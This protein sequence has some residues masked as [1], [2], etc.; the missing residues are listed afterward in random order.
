[1]IPE[2]HQMEH[3]AGRNNTYVNVSKPQNT[4]P[5]YQKN[6]SPF[7]TVLHIFAT[8][9]RDSW[10]SANHLHCWTALPIFQHS[11]P[12]KRCSWAWAN[13]PFSGLY[14]S[15]LK[16]SNLNMTFWLSAYRLPCTSTQ[17]ISERFAALKHNWENQQ[18]DHLAGPHYQY[19]NVSKPETWFLRIIKSTS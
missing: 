4:I 1:M 7:M 2:N 17:S 19:L 6:L 10:A 18:N 15:Y 5:K 3:I 16:V 13:R 9:K 11:A 12:W 14:C 8:R